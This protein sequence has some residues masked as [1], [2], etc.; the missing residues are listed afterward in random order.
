MDLSRARGVALLVTAAVTA[1]LVLAAGLDAPASASARGLSVSFRVVGAGSVTVS[2][3][4]AAAS[5]SVRIDRRS[6]SGWSFVKRIRAH[7]HRYAT[8]VR[9]PAGSAASFRVLSMGGARA[10]T[11]RMPAPPLASAPAASYD[12]CGARPLKANG[13]PW[14]CTFVDNFDGTEL[15]RTK[16]LPQ[17][18]F[19]QGTVETHAC[20]RDD[21]SNV[22]VRGGVLNLTLLRLDEPAPCGVDLSPTTLQSGMVSTWHRFSQQYGRFEA[23][24]KTT[25]SSYP[26]LHETFWMWP[27]NRVASTAK[28]PDAGEI[29]V[30]ESYSSAPHTVIPFLHYS[31]DSGGIQMGLNTNYCAAERGVWNTYTLEWS[32]SRLEVFVNGRSCLVNTS[33]DPAF[34][35]PYIID[36]TQGIGPQSNLPVDGTPI[37]ATM[38]VDYVRVW[39]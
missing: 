37:P 2:G 19:A 11:V 24:I 7:G 10:F 9:V 17:T 34:Q 30:A 13:T 1:A 14:S 39:Q 6:G 36:L 12:A 29:D 4:T 25:A 31:A 32:A 20:Y 35:K 38:Q 8:T 3:R 33:G 21:P 28:W 16:W 23:R 26:G 27:D 18:V 22:N 15:D 5:P